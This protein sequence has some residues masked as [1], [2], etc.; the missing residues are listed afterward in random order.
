MNRKETLIL[1]AAILLGMLVGVGTLALLHRRP[2][3]E[4][5]RA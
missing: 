2:P 4:P 1:A 5:Q 3:A